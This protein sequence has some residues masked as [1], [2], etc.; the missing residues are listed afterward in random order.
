MVTDAFPPVVETDWTKTG[1]AER[2]LGL[3]VYAQFLQT[4]MGG[5]GP[6]LNVEHSNQTGYT[7][8]FDTVTTL[9]FEP[10]QEYVQEAVKAPGVQLWLGQYRQKLA[11]VNQLFMITGIKIV[12]GARIGHSTSEST[13]FNSNLGIEAAALGTTI[14]PKGHWKSTN[15]DAGASS[16]E[17]EFVFAFR[18]KKL[19]F[20]RKLKLQE[21]NKGA[22][23]AVGGNDDDDDDECVLVEDVHGADIETAVAVP[24]AAEGG[25]VYCVPG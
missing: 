4:V 15:A 21:Y 23:M 10:T 8:A 16:Q 20:G 25:N 18:V 11:L 12:K 7:L 1:S 17:S 6:A 2:E 14:G 3:G 5:F 13:M 24:D 9:A 19:K 22:F